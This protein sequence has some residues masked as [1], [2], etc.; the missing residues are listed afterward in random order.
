MGSQGGV[1]LVTILVYMIVLHGR[2]VWRLGDFGMAAG[3]VIGV[4]AV[5]WTWYGVSFLMS[6]GKHSYA[7]G[8]GGKWFLMAFLAANAVYLAAV[9]V[10]YAV[11]HLER[12]RSE[13]QR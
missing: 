10:R 8:S 12:P 5:G 3:S 7:E 2:H 9:I 6:A 1:A 4:V 11:A 13:S